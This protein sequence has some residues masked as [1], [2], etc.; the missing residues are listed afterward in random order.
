MHQQEEDISVK[1]K[2]TLII[3]ILL[4]LQNLKQ[5][6]INNAMKDMVLGA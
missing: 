5:D 1:L 3:Q 4:K 6:D 2:K